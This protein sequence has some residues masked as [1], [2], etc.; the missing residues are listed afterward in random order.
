MPS[1]THVRTLQNPIA[2]V[3]LTRVGV[4]VVMG[5]LPEDVVVLAAVDVVELPGGTVVVP[6]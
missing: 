1:Y 4:G 6:V 2:E 3:R 5:P